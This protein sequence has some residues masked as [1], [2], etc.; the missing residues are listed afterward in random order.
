MLGLLQS[1]VNLTVL[2]TWRKCLL[3]YAVPGADTC[4]EALCDDQLTGQ[5]STA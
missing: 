5:K 3:Q 1:T 4:L 2:I